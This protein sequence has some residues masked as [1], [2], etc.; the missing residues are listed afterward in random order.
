MPIKII[1]DSISDLPESAAREFGITV[2]PCYINIGEKSYLDGFEM[3]H[4]EFYNQLPSLAVLPK[5]ASPN[6]KAFEGAYVQAADEGATH[7]I[8]I[9]VAGT[10]SSVVDTARM[11]AG[12]VQGVSV[13]VFDSGTVSMGMGFLAMAA[14]R[15]ASAGKSVAE[16]VSL[17]KA[18][19]ER[20]IIFVKLDTVDYLRRSGRV[21]RIQAGLATFLHIFPVLKVYQ[22]VVDLEKVRTRARAFDRLLEMAEA[23]APLEDL[24]VMHTNCLEKAEMIRQKIEYLLPNRKIWVGEATPAIGTHVG[25]DGIGLVCV[26]SE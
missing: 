12:A 24:A 3:S 21:S 14:A 8:S 16:I 6:Q 22:G 23:Y 25:P 4:Q 26:R 11:A 1:T 19:A 5:T 7:I 15:A 13:T 18:K 20:T 2:V 10:F 9:H 17:L